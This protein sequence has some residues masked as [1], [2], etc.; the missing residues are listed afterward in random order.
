MALTDSQTSAIIYH[1]E[2][3]APIKLAT[4]VSKGDVIGWAVTGG[5]WKQADASTDADT[6]IPIHAR[7][8]AASDGVI[9][10]HITAY[11]GEVTMGGRFSG[12]TV[13]GAVYASA[14]AGQYTQTIPATTGDATTVIGY[15]MSPTRL[16][17][18]PSMNKESES[19]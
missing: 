17:L 11:F 15:A 13:G 16:T 7:C 9:G 8:I 5:G 18:F 3:P 1:G 6:A 2:S 19:A 14:T 4:A 10:Q 12:A